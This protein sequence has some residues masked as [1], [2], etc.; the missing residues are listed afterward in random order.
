MGNITESAARRLQPAGSENAEPDLYASV[1][2]YSRLRTRAQPPDIEAQLASHDKVLLAAQRILLSRG[3]DPQTRKMEHYLTQQLQYGIDLLR[4]IDLVHVPSDDKLED[5]F[6]VIEL[7][8][9]ATQAEISI[10]AT[11][12][13]LVMVAT[14]YGA[15]RST[16]VD[17][18]E[19]LSSILPAEHFA[20]LQQLIGA[21]DRA[22]RQSA[23]LS[24]AA[25]Y[26]NTAPP[27][28]NGSAL[29]LQHCLELGV[30][31]AQRWE[32]VVPWLLDDSQRVLQLSQVATVDEFERFCAAVEE[33]IAISTVYAEQDA[34][35]DS[36][37]CPI[38][39]EGLFRGK[40]GSDGHPRAPILPMPAGCNHVLCYSCGMDIMV[41][42]KECPF[43]RKP[44]TAMRSP[45]TAV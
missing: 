15:V 12:P 30:A 11:H 23:E 16:L 3:H 20:L 39:F 41:K 2:L 26:S 31:V 19:N 42:F 37:C 44:F 21:F 24:S 45:A 10:P 36:N 5:G 8:Q 27:P 6:V 33:S 25:M 38:C 32:Q 7:N 35:F 1:C 40:V 14:Q 22:W 28:R 4:N 29:R 17:S 34:L 43:C 18:I 13:G 9:P